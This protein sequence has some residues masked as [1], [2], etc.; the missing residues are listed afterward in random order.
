M[1]TYKILVTVLDQFGKNAISEFLFRYST[2]TDSEYHLLHVVEPPTP[3]M[4]GDPKWEAARASCYRTAEAVLAQL[5]ATLR[6]IMPNASFIEHI[7]EGNPADE[8]VKLAEEERASLIVLGTRGRKGLV[9][10]LLGSV[11][12]AVSHRAPCSVVILRQ[13]RLAFSHKEDKMQK[14]K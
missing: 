9:R 3:R 8:I 14:V 6:K 11:S 13:N 12:S 1:P 10:L 2:G 4:P 7:R 5:T